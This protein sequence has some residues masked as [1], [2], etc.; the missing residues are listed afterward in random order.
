LN[1]IQYSN[2][3]NKNSDL[4]I[5]IFKFPYSNV[6]IISIIININFHNINHYTQ[7]FIQ[8]NN[9]LPL[10]NFFFFSNLKNLTPII[11][12]N[13]SCNPIISNHFLL[14]KNTFFQSTKF[15]IQTQIYKE[16]NSIQY[17]NTFLLPQ[18]LQ[19]DS[20][21]YSYSK[22]LTPKRTIKFQNFEYS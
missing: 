20:K 1:I 11:I 9:F 22:N 2:Q 13:I 5:L 8:S 7:L 6:M 10:K 15:N 4:N 16:S 3:V 19:T 14:L 12:H 17:P 21:Y 18:N